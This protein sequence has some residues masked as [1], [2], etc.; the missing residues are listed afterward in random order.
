MRRSTRSW[1]PGSSLGGVLREPGGSLMPLAEINAIHAHHETRVEGPPLLLIFGAGLD[2]SELSRFIDSLA[3]RH[4]VV[5]FDRGAGRSDRPDEP[6]S[7]ELMA[8][9]TFGVMEAAGLE[10]PCR[11][12]WHHDRGTAEWHTGCLRRS[13]AAELV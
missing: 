10:Q 8:S 9:D 1:I 6:Y 11:A 12:R 13:S 5:A 3:A 2:V 7:I 4:R